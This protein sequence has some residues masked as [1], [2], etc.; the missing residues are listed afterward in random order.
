MGFTTLKNVLVDWDKYD[1]DGMVYLPAGT[2]PSLDAMVIVLP[3]DPAKDRRL[4][5][6]EGFIGLEQLRDAVEGLEAHRGRATT[7][8]ERLRAAIHYARYDAFIDP[9]AALDG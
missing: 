6:L 4:E 8:G 3:F 2:D 7:P 9:S 1:P 5:D